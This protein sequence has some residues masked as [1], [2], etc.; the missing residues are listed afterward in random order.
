MNNFRLFFGLIL[1]LALFILDRLIKYFIILKPLFSEGV[2]LWPNFQLK[3]FLN[4]NLALS[5]PVSNWLAGGL[6]FCLIILIIILGFK[7]AIKNT[8]LLWGF[9]LIL[10]GSISN[11]LD[12]IKFGGVIDYLDWWIFPVFNL[13]DVF[14]FCGCLLLLWHFKKNDL[15]NNA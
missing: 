13:S 8:T 1:L 12:R 9:G 7:F 11:L 5:L 4:A 15:T 14:I 3:L 2:L 6:S 10:I